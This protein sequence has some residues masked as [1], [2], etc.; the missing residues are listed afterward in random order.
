M[1][2]E[3]A[4]GDALLAASQA[5]GMGTLLIMAYL[6]EDVTFNHAQ[7]KPGF[8]KP[9]QNHGCMLHYTTVP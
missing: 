4:Q 5:E 6:A 1:Y 9:L 8:A 3:Q 2:H 7:H